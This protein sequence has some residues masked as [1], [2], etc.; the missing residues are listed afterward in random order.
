MLEHRISYQ[1]GSKAC[2]TLKS[3]VKGNCMSLDHWTKV[4]IRDLFLEAVIN[5]KPVLW[6]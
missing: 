3:E 6:E 5:L 1:V 4:N 2:Y